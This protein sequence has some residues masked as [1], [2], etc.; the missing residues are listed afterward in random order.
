[1]RRIVCVA[2]AAITGLMMW[3][4]CKKSVDRNPR[5]DCVCKFKSTFT[6]HD[7]ST[8]SEFPAV[9]NSNKAAADTSCAHYQVALQNHDTAAKCTLY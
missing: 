5:Y 4:S 6:G 1:M 7:T 9:T 3:G 8:D 2:L